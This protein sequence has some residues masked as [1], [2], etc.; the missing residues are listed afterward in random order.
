MWGMLETDLTG[1]PASYSTPRNRVWSGPVSVALVSEE[2]TVMLTLVGQGQAAQARGQLYR[3][4]GSFA[5]ELS[6]LTRKILWV[7]RF[8]ARPC[9]P[10]PSP[11]GKIMPCSQGT[12]YA[13]DET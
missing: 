11:N 12:A 8:P 10:V 7:L 3:P 6:G 13:Q 4:Q 5:E 9:F 1:V 2:R